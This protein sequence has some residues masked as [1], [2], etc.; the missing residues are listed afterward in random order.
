MNK[1][2]KLAA[3]LFADIQGYTALMQKDEQ[4]ASILLRHFQQQLEEKVTAHKGQIVNFY[5][6]GA[7]CTFQIPID[8]VRCGM[9]L[10][11]AFRNKPTVPVRIG[12]HSGTVTLE[13]DKIFG[14]SVNITARIESMGVA[15]GILL[16]KKVRDEVKNN[17]DLR[18][19]SLGSFEFKN[20]EEPMEV[21]AL[22]NDGLVIPKRS[23]MKGKIKT[24]KKN[25]WLI[26][27]IIGALLLLV[28][29]Y[30]NFFSSKS[31]AL[32]EPDL[33]TAN[34][35]LPPNVLNERV[36]IIPIQ[37]NTTDKELDILGKMAADW[38]N[39]GLMDIENA[40]VVSPY[41]V[42]QHL[43]AI[44]ILPNNAQGKP[45]FSELTGARNFIQGSFYQEKEELIFLMELVDALD[46]KIKFKFPDI[47]GNTQEKE[48]LITQLRENIAGYWATRDLVD[49]KRIKA[50]KYEA[51]KSYLK[52]LEQ[53]GMDENPLEAIRLD[54]T[55]YMARIHFLIVNK[56]GTFGPNKIHLD[57]FNRHKEHLSNY[58][59]GWV[60]SFENLYQGN[61]LLA[62][63]SLNE[64]RK[65]YPNDFYLNHECAGMANDLLRNPELS[66]SI[67]E[68]LPLDNIVPEK[69]GEVYNWRLMHQVSNYLSTNQLAKSKQFIKRYSPNKNAN[70]TWYQ[71]TVLLDAFKRNDNNKIVQAKKDFFASTGPRV[72][73]SS[74]IFFDSN[75]FLSD[76]QEKELKSDFINLYLQRKEQ[77]NVALFFSNFYAYLAKQ[78]KEIRLEIL[79]ELPKVIQISQLFYAG[80]TYL[81]T[82]LTQ[83]M[84]YII[85]ELEK[86]TI[87]EGQV[88]PKTG[89]G[90][91][92]YAL[93]VLY[94]Q[95]GQ[96]EK[97]LT[98]LRQAKKYSA[99][100]RFQYD[101]RLAPLFDM[102]E[103]Q[104]IAEPIWP[105]IL[106]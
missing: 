79:S 4:N 25:K 106:D 104:E 99:M 101:K 32:S 80:L 44:G 54:S 17:P 3:I 50:P 34:T 43:D 37:N 20:V 56:G 83:R 63:N 78:P 51:Y 14:N 30:W 6:D 71:S 67:Y 70:W 39:R 84:D 55:F 46:G 9:A 97:A 1:K 60:T 53:G 94:T 31:M 28:I 5:G 10:Q 59:A 16:S 36:A 40:E 92:Q 76:A 8:A 85:Q 57:F 102:P 52:R 61:S 73:F 13:G 45:S 69:L 15:G 66:M 23:E 89:G 77:P 7:L 2:R 62:F 100:G 18:M 88:F 64:I 74:V 24:T 22:A 58:E 29:G 21:F 41:T 81:E 11:T 75:I 48:A 47:R 98:A 38:I 105:K 65:K 12:I 93:G 27:S 19:Q 90:Y 86:R 103:F 96:Y 68:E 33:L 35:P 26:P 91:A 82:G 42:N 95:M 49:S 87:I 72:F